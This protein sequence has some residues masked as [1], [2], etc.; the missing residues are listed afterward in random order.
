MNSEIISDKNN[1]FVSLP[2]LSGFTSPQPAASGKPSI[3]CVIIFYVN[4]HGEESELIEL[5]TKCRKL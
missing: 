2:D 3:M 5:C 4:N 1:L